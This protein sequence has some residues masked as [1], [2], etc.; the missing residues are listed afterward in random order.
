VAL[1]IQGQRR[2]NE[3]HRSLTEGNAQVGV[4]SLEKKGGRTTVALPPFQELLGARI[5]RARPVQNKHEVDRN[6]TQAS[7]APKFGP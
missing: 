5:H 3:A 2:D 4:R 7:H 1:V 6:V